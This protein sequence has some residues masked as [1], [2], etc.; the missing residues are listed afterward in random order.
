MAPL[1][2]TTLISQVA[3]F[4]RSLEQRR[5]VREQRALPA[6]TGHLSRVSYPPSAALWPR[7]FAHIAPSSS[8]RF[9]PRRSPAVWSPQAPSPRSLLPPFLRASRPV[10]V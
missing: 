4:A 10:R 8:A 5:P 7:P 1:P 9:L 6:S 2:C 3:T